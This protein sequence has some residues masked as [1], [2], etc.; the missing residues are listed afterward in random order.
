MGLSSVSTALAYISSNIPTGLLV[1][2]LLWVSSAVFQLF[3]FFGGFTALNFTAIQQSSTPIHPL[4]VATRMGPC[5]GAQG[6]YGVGSGS[7]EGAIAQ[8]ADY[9]DEIIW[10]LMHPLN[11]TW[12][13]L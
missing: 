7:W 2:L 13:W 11:W 9:L 10:Q 3:A 8:K 12:F 6:A 5:R 1:W 4:P